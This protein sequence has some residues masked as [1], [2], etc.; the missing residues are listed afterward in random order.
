MTTPRATP[1]II[2]DRGASADAPE[3]TIA[4]FDLALDQGADGIAL[5]V[6]LT[7]D[8]QPVVIHDF[9]L[10]RTTDGAGTVAAHTMRELKRLDAGAWRSRRFQGQRVQTLQEVL[11]RFRGR[12]RFWIEI[13]GGSDLYPDIEERVVSMIEIYEAVDQTLIQSMDLE[14]LARI[15]TVNP[16]ITL[17]AVVLGSSLEPFL[18]GTSPAQVLSLLPERL[19]EAAGS[20]IRRVGLACYVRAGDD[21]GSLERLSEWDV[22]GIITARP[23]LVRT[24]L[25]R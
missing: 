22:D 24:R 4:A 6:H 1:L 3:H 21:P 11:E 20:E 8:G 7:R 16:D 12:T 25:G 19:T 5:D 14:S 2:A 15:R 18:V 13:R 9:T 23:S 10:E 17:G